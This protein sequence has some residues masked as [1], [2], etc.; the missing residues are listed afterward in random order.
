MVNAPFKTHTMIEKT[1][2]RSN[3]KA[4]SDLCIT[5]ERCRYDNET[6]SPDMISIGD[7]AG[8]Y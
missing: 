3:Q 5:F 7:K 4:I 8:Y 1:F 6:H 2:K